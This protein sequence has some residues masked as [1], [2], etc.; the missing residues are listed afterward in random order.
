MRKDFMSKPTKR[1]RRCLLNSARG[2]TTCNYFLPIMIDHQCSKQ[3]FTKISA[4][5]PLGNKKVQS[6]KIL[7]SNLLLHAGLNNKKPNQVKREFQRS[8]VFFSKQITYTMIKSPYK[9]TSELQLEITMTLSLIVLANSLADNKP[10]R[11]ID[12]SHNSS[13]FHHP[14]K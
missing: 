12:Y 11:N 3:D 4:I 13:I 6:Q 8:A 7:A 5:L 2:H 1:Q 14:P 9:E 10:S